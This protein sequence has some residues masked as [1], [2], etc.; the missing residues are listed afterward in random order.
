MIIVFQVFYSSST[1][2]ARLIESLSRNTEAATFNIKPKDMPVPGLGPEFGGPL[3]HTTHTH[4]HSH[5]PGHSH[6]SSLQTDSDV[7]FTVEERL[8]RMI[9]RVNGG[10]R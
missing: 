6:S 3:P 10:E 4:A 2:I 5:I 9:D 7:N 8:D 1:Q